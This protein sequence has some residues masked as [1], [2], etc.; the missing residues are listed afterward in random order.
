MEAAPQESLVLAGT[1]IVILS[2]WLTNKGQLVW[3]SLLSSM[4]GIKEDQRCGR[5]THIGPAPSAEVSTEEGA[6]W[7]RGDGVT[8]S[9]D[10]VESKEA[11][12]R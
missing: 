4:R 1:R 10:E 2:I 12:M 9:T 11:I 6:V 8:S 7:T 5:A 3:D